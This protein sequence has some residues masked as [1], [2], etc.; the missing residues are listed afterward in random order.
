MKT[1]FVKSW[2]TDYVIKVL[3]NTS[4][5]KAQKMMADF[6][7]RRLPVVDKDGRLIGIIT[8]SDIRG[9][10]RDVSMAETFREFNFLLSEYQVKDVM[11]PTPVVVFKDDT[12][13][14][15]ARQMLKHHVSGL[16][17]VNHDGNVVGI[18]TE[19]DIF[20]MVVLQEWG[21][22]KET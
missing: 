13:G 6:N 1:E 9:V 20:S 22:L 10:E 17:V 12:V 14:F 3:P 19:S 11:T 4:I 2:M 21:E 15:A 16:P 5:L 18:I 7:I 8:Q